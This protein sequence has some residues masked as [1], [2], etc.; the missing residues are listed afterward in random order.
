MKKETNVLRTTRDLDHHDSAIWR[1]ND[2]SFLK[3][4]KQWQNTIQVITRL[5]LL[6]SAATTLKSQCT[7]LETYPIAY[8]FNLYLIYNILVVCFV[9]YLVSSM[10]QY[11]QINDRSKDA[12]LLESNGIIELPTKRMCT[13][14]NF[15]FFS[16]RRTCEHMREFW[17]RGTIF[18]L[19]K[20]KKKRSKNL[21]T[22]NNK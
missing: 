14:M 16:W 3:W 10:K 6:H 22:S 21:N 1:D 15:C 5:P 4:H 18:F 8:Q 19:K 2:N 9:F 13:V 11:G 17:F 20:P 7:T 12:Q